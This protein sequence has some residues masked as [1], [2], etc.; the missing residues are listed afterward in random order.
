MGNRAECPV[1]KSYSSGVY[2][3]LHYDN[4]PCPYC[5]AP[6]EILRDWNNL[7][8]ELEVLQS[9]RID[10]DLVH[11][12]KDV[13]QENAVLKTKLSRLENLLGYDDTVVKPILQAIKILNNQEEEDDDKD[14][15]GYE[16]PK[17][18]PY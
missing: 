4:N 15:H 7:K 3:A 8:E 12:I 11:Q 18:R 10:K 14:P 1:C 9:K 6:F 2:Q 16:F 13:M 17:H 5:Q